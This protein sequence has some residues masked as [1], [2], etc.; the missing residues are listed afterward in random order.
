[1]MEVKNSRM[2][3]GKRFFSHCCRKEALLFILVFIAQ[4]FPG[5]RAEPAKIPASTFGF[6]GGSPYYHFSRWPAKQ[7]THRTTKYTGV[8]AS[9][10]E[11]SGYTDPGT[12]EWIPGFEFPSNS[13]IEYLGF[14]SLWVGGIIGQDTLVSTAWNWDGGA[15]LYTHGGREFFPPA[16]PQG[17]KGLIPFTVGYSQ[18]YRAIFVDT[19]TANVR[20]LNRDFFSDR[21][22]IPM[23][24]S[25]IQK[26]YSWNTSPYQNILL[27]DYTITNIGHLPIEDAYI[28]IAVSG[29]VCGDRD[30]DGNCG[31]DDLTGSLRDISTAYVIDNDGDPL[32]GIFQDSLSPIDA[33]A[34]RPVLIYPPVTDTNYNWW[35]IGP[36]GGDW[37]DFGPRQKGTPSDPFRDFRT[38]GIG[39]PNGDVN[40]YYIMRHREWDYDQVMTATID[41]TDSIWLYPDQSIAADLSDGENPSFLLSVGP[42]QLPPDGLMRAVFALFGGDFVHIDPANQANLAM[43]RYR[44]YYEHLHFDLL[45]QTADYALD[46]VDTMLSPMQ[47][48]TGLEVVRMSADTAVLT[49][50]P[51]VLPDITGYSIYVKPVDEAYLMAPN[52]VLPGAA[53]DDMGNRIYHFPAEST[54]GIITGL[55]PGWLYFAAIAHE[56][57]TGEGQL[58]PPVVL[59]YNNEALQIPPVA[60]SREFVFY[61]PGD[62]IVTLRWQDTSDPRIRYYRI[63]K[64]LDS[65]LANDRYYPFVTDDSSL[66]SYLPRT[67]R[68]VDGVTYCYYEIQP[69]DS[70]ASNVSYYIDRDP[71]PGAMYW[72]SAVGHSSYFS[73]YS[74]ILSTEELSDPT[75]DIVVVLGASLN[76]SD[77]V[78]PDSL[79]TY[80]TRLLDG[81]DFDLYNWFDTNRV[82]N[83]PSKYCTDWRDLARYRVII[84]EEFPEPKIL[85]KKTEPVYKL[86]TRLMDAG[87]VVV[88]FGPPPGDEDMVGLSSSV[89]SIGYDSTSFELCYFGLDSA[90]LKSWENS[91]RTLGAVDSLA[92][93]NAAV[94]VAEELPPL[95]LDTVNNRFKTWIQQAFTI[96]NTLPLTPAFYPRQGVEVLYQ[97]NS[98]F[99]ATSELHGLPCGVR[100][101]HGSSTAYVFSFHLWA[102]EETGARRLLDYI[103]SRQASDTGGQPPPLPET[104]RLY[105]NYPNPFNTATTISFELPS[106]TWVTLDIYNIL[107]QHVC[108]LVDENRT[109][110][111]HE[112]QW[113]G[114]D[115]RGNTVAS[116]VYF[117]RLK[118]GEKLLTK[119]MLLLK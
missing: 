94:P 70:T 119:K 16:D 92:G 18:S 77:Y 108:T 40:K 115:G 33:L 26:S 45:R 23:N 90:V 11:V 103:I 61:Q 116:G 22:H 44:T 53:P 110:G 17:E 99:P 75:R 28:G 84:V 14:A 81:H 69:Y 46:F 2:S 100:H 54:K 112:V 59:G 64:T 9:N 102:M 83:C 80:Y 25:V 65:A 72:V 36:W 32:G 82:I 5:D 63:Y 19:F 89:N 101:R 109:T 55:T 15:G 114:R 4:G 66:F 34:L 96:D 62:S 30:G 48:P 27:L 56:T 78:I 113:D 35:L 67:C 79:T 12:G 98:R 49:W 8:V 41:S 85:H 97:Y 74:S 118:A 13:G 52:V 37:Y 43:K 51:R 68:E 7:S 31:E 58:S 21:P 111:S 117:Y 73:P 38:T 6:T 47:P 50:D 71:I 104:V 39:S 87:R 10:G 42:V 93:F 106:P 88:Y 95:F 86:L 107:G 57:E 20:W 24:L 60:T 76:E 1:M 29:Y 105:Q 91:Y 3:V